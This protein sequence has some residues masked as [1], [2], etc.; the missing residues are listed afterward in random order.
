MLQLEPFITGDVVL[1]VTHDLEK[2]PIP[3]FIGQHEL[4]SVVWYKR[5]ERILKGATVGLGRGLKGK[6]GLG[7]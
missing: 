6:N 1:A 5:E 3:S 4:Y 7:S 2:V